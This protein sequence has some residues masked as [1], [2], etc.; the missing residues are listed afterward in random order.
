[1]G[2]GGTGT[3]LEKLKSLRSNKLKSIIEGRKSLLMDRRINSQALII[4]NSPI[5]KS[6]WRW[7]L[8]VR[9]SGGMHFT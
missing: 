7:K 6:P 5:Q 2:F 4:E 3:R 8:G 1:M 9:G